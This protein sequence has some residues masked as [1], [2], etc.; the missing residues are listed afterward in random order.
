MRHL[1][2]HADTLAQC[3]V[4]VD[5]FSDVHGVSAHFDGERDLADHVARVGAHDARQKTRG[6][7]QRRRRPP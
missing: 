2:R 5:G 3:G 7:D 6:S 4:G 1:S